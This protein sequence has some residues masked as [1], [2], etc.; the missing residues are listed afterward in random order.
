M[1]TAPILLGFLLAATLCAEAPDGLA[2]DQTRALLEKSGR[3]FLASLE[4][5]SPTQWNFQPT[6][7]RHSIGELAEHASMSTND[8]Q[9]LIEKALETGPQ[10]DLVPKLDG[11]LETIKSIMLDLEDPPDKFKP[12]NRLS[13]KADIHEYY[14]QVHRRAL[15]L[16]RGAAQ[17]ELCIFRHPNKRLEEMNAL[18]WFA[19]IAY[20]TQAHTEQIE[21]I[22]QHA[23]YPPG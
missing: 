10:P 17:P 8:L 6:G 12:R 7:H 1:R 20:L 18:Q 4:G 2:A 15:S 16:L 11:K 19:Y 9:S 3:E 23:Q 13:T 5:V 14:P 21:R 22:K